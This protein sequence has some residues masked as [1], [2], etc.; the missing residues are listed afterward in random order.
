MRR[1]AA[2][3]GDGMA[4]RTTTAGEAGGT[5]GGREWW[6]D[7]VIY[8]VYPRSF[9]DSDG[10]GVGD[11]PGIT[12]RLP[13]I[14]SL[15][16]DAV[17]LSPFFASPRP[18]HGLRRLRLHGRRPPVRHPRRFRRAGGR[19]APRWASR[20]SSTRCCRHSSD[21]HPWFAREPAGPHQRAR[22]LVRL[23]RPQAR[24][25][26][27]Q[28][29]ARRCSA[30]RPG[31]FDPRRRQYYLHNFLTE[32][33][34]LN[35]HKPAVVDAHLANMRF[36]LERGVDGFRLDTVNFF[37]HDAQL[38]DN[39]PSRLDRV[40]EEP[41]RGAGPPVLQ[42]PGREPRGAQADAGADRR[43]RRHHDGGRGRRGRAPDRHHGGLHVG[44]RQAAHGLLVRVPGP[45]PHRRA[46]PHPDRAVPRQG[47]GRLALL[48]LLEPRRD[49]PRH[50]LDLARRRRR[51]GRPAVGRAALRASPAR[52]ASTRARS[53]ARSRPT[54]CSRS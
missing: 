47:A 33:P 52:S 8:Q 46:L 9:Q 34:D 14:A 48:V 25:L 39:P 45:R 41:L 22:R 27:A 30:A 51:R 3:R 40:P 44:R 7:A 43:V 29:L 37:V 12:R 17:W 32:Q 6:R 42:D 10:D 11:L 1:T 28:Q 2:K 26:A 21:Q 15:G 20:S 18:R 5:A 54:S 24:R 4:K 49:A 31:T 16:V 19:G 53:W 38:R 36:W 35:F 50:A 23:G 13:H